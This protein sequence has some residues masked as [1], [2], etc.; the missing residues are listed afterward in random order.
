[1]STSGTTT[2]TPPE[3]AEAPVPAR[4]VRRRWLDERAV[5]GPLDV[6]VALAAFLALQVWKAPVL[7]VVA[8][9]AA[10]GWLL[11]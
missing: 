8:A 9:T 3:T 6:A 1:M 4:V 5:R 10:A 2:S 11:L 7:A